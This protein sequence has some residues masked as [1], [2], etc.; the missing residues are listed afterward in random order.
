MLLP[1]F[2]IHIRA[3]AHRALDDAEDRLKDSCAKQASR[4]SSYYT[5]NAHYIDDDGK[6]SDAQNKADAAFLCNRLKGKLSPTAADFESALQALYDTRR[7]RSIKDQV[8]ARVM[9]DLKRVAKAQLKE[10]LSAVNAIV[11]ED[12][13]GG[14]RA[15]TE[16]LRGDRTSLEL[17]CEAPARILSREDIK[18]TI[19][20]CKKNESDLIGL[21]L[22]SRAVLQEARSEARGDDEFGGGAAAS[23]AGASAPLSF[24]EK[25]AAASSTHTPSKTPEHNRTM[26]NIVKCMSD[27]MKANPGILI[28]DLRT[29]LK[30]TEQEQPAFTAAFAN[31]SA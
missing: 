18:K 21:G 12:L 16:V 20:V 23:G 28:R 31:L 14:L 3:L 9:G 2:G 5:R 29:R 4:S 30:I 17:A 22:G 1:A 10:F 25:L 6:P 7:P 19:G 24:Q 27:L 8:V 26:E 13:V 15:W 11:K